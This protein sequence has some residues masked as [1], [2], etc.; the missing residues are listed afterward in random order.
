[1]PVTT[2]LRQIDYDTFDYYTQWP[3]IYQAGSANYI[4]S[5]GV[6]RLWLKFD[7]PWNTFMTIK[8][9]WGGSQ[10]YDQKVQ[11]HTYYLDSNYNL[12]Y[13]TVAAFG[14][15]TG[16]M[17]SKDCFPGKWEN[18]GDR[19]WCFVGSKLYEYESYGS[20]AWANNKAKLSTLTLRTLPTGTFKPRNPSACRLGNTY[21]K[22]F[23]DGSGNYMC[24]VYIEY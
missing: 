3:E 16:G 21:F 7:D 17:I 1:M 5:N 4:R 19:T 9:M 20:T 18:W 15:N 11:K 10:H 6:Y 8:D 22:I 12:I 24:E 14:K 23:R 2:E 13:D